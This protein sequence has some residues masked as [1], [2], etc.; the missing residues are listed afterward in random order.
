MHFMHMKSSNALVSIFLSV[1]IITSAACH[2]TLSDKSL[3]SDVAGANTH[4]RAE[5]I[6][7]LLRTLN[8]QGNLPN[9]I[10]LKRIML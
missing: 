10:V 4:T 1:L 5:Q 6:D 2:N 9:N 3:R 8:E 7:R